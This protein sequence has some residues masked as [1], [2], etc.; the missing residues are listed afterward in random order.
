MEGLLL[1]VRRWSFESAKFILSEQEIIPMMLEKY[2]HCRLRAKRSRSSE[3]GV[4][5]QILRMD[6]GSP[7]SPADYAANEE[8]RS[9]G[10]GWCPSFPAICPFLSMCI[11]SIPAWVDCAASN[12]LNPSIGRVTRVT[13]QSSYS[14]RL[15]R[16]LSWRISMPASYSAS[17]CS[18]A[19]VLAPLSSMVI[20]SGMP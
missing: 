13:P 15:L 16:Y 17:S 14:T 1:D 4:L 6:A 8:T 19:T 7:V 12:D 9:A 2:Q 20:F 3:D 11:S 5:S 10:L 18:I